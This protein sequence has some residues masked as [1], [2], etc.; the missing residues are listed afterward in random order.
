MDVKMK[1]LVK[2]IAYSDNKTFAFTPNDLTHMLANLHLAVDEI[3]RSI[4]IIKDVLLKNQEWRDGLG[5]D[6]D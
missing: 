3:D 4:E 6:P 5:I 1:K 2:Y